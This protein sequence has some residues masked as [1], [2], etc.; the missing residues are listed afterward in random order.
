MRHRR[1]EDYKPNPLPAHFSR[2]ELFEENDLVLGVWESTAEPN[3]VGTL[4]LK[5]ENVLRGIA[6]GHERG[7]AFAA[8]HC[9]SQMEAMAIRSVFGDG[10]GLDLGERPHDQCGR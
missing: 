2:Q 7:G 10:A 5:G 1:T 6:K 8:I 3:G 4:I 9:K